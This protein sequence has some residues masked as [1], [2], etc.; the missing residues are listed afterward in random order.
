[1]KTLR[2]QSKRT[3]LGETWDNLLQTGRKCWIEGL[4][5]QAFAKLHAAAW[6]PF[7]PMDIR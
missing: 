3:A 5:C 7:D 4:G 2:K 1:L 6:T